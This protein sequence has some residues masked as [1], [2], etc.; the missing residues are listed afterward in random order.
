MA[1]RSRPSSRL[2]RLAGAFAVCVVWATVLSA[3]RGIPPPA[4]WMRDIAPD[5]GTNQDLQ[6][7]RLFLIVIDDAAIQANVFAMK[8]VREVAK[9]TIDRFGPSDLA[10]VV[11]TRDN[12]NSQDFTADRARL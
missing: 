2:R 3:Q 5:V 11:F 8:S 1:T 4:P 12:R 7:R 6:E 9:R 10:A